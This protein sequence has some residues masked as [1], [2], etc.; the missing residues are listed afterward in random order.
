MFHVKHNITE[1][2]KG[3]DIFVRLKERIEQ[4]EKMRQSQAVNV[5]D[6]YS[7]GFYNGLEL[8]MSV[9]DG[10]EPEYMIA[11]KEPKIVEKEQK[12]GRTK[13]SGVIKKRG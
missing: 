3:S 11:E 12:Q 13:A 2:N 4:V 10:R 1:Q 5:N 8:A 9:L 7:A 6:E